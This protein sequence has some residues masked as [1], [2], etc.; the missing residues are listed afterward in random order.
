M[1]KKHALLWL[2]CKICASRFVDGLFGVFFLL[3]LLLLLN[4]INTIDIVRIFFNSAS[5]NMRIH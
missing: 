4:E 5:K 3:L 1:E 2:F